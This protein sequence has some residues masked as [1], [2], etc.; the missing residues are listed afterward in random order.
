MAMRYSSLDL[1]GLKGRGSMRT[2]STADPSGP[3][4]L[5]IAMHS[6]LD[7]IDSISLKWIQV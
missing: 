7:M 1:K 4:P 2:T 3:N 6:S 5:S